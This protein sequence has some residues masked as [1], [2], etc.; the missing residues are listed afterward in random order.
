VGEPDAIPGALEVLISGEDGRP[1][2]VSAIYAPGAGPALDDTILALGAWFEFERPAPGPY[3]G[4]FSGG[5]PRGWEAVGTLSE[6]PGT[7]M[8]L[9]VEIALVRA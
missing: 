6:P 3:Q 5:A 8:R 7:E 9:L 4:A 1:E 2:A